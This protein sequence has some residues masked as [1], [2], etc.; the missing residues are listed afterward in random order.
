MFETRSTLGWGGALSCN[1]SV[2]CKVQRGFD[3]SWQVYTQMQ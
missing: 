2:G 1:V 3:L